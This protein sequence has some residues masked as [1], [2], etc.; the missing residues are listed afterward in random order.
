MSVFTK[1]GS[2]LSFILP[3][4]YIVDRYQKKVISVASAKNSSLENVV[5]RAHHSGDFQKLVKAALGPI[6][7]LEIVTNQAKDPPIVRNDVMTRLCTG[8]SKE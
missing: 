4:A 7:N 5:E 6:E 1:V 3:Q 2:L 8:P